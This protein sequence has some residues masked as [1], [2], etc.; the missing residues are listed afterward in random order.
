MAEYLCR[1]KPEPLW[2]TIIDS[3]DK[4]GIELV[5]TDNTSAILSHTS[6]TNLC[7]LNIS[8]NPAKHE[9][10]TILSL[11][12]HAKRFFGWPLRIMQVVGITLPLIGFVLL[13]LADPNNRT[14]AGTLMIGGITLMSLMIWVLM[15]PHKR[16]Y[17]LLTALI[18]DVKANHAVKQRSA[19]S[20]ES[21]NSFDD[22][23]FLISLLLII[24]SFL[25]LFGPLLGTILAVPLAYVF[26]YTLHEK[27]NSCSWRKYYHSLHGAWHVVC[28]V[29]ITILFLQFF[30]G[31]IIHAMATDNNGQGVSYIESALQDS[32]L[33]SM[34]PEQYAYHCLDQAGVRAVLANIFIAGN[35]V[36]L[37]V[38]LI[39]F[40][41]VQ[42]AFTNQKG[43]IELSGSSRSL[44]LFKPIEPYSGKYV[45]IVL[46]TIIS[47]IIIWTYVLLS[48][49]ILAF[50]LT[51]EPVFFNWLD[52]IIALFTQMATRAGIPEL[53]ATIVVYFSY[54]LLIAPAI[55]ALLINF[56]R[57]IKLIVLQYELYSGRYDALPEHYQEWL[58]NTCKKESI[59][60]PQIRIIKS[61]APKIYAEGSIFKGKG[62]IVISDSCFEDFMSDEIKAILAHELAHVKYDTHIL[63]RLKLLSILTLCPFYYI[64]M[65]YDFPGRELKADRFAASVTHNPKALI[66]ALIGLH[67][68]CDLTNR[69]FISKRLRLLV[70]IRRVLPRWLFS[71]GSYYDSSLFSVAYP[72]RVTR[73]K[74]ILIMKLSNGE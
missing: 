51:K 1:T 4:Q 12:S 37:V 52:W 56:C 69:P 16:T 72:S 18:R 33:D 6:W 41:Y 30:T 63:S 67:L 39:L 64:L 57:L 44:H 46:Y 42:Y 28:L 60:F 43:M 73:L 25:L 66:S 14:L 61:S 32:R 3:C 65:M 9:Y 11:S 26:A 10:G 19:F 38:F 50:M 71:V 5:R 40:V 34:Q 45:W 48:V 55:A 36:L 49:D 47:S 74:N 20:I 70:K 31:S 8:T 59:P 22:W 23:Y 2:R 13:L 68:R 7:Q 53:F 29:A 24:I 35:I 17:K 15:I 27:E 54:I 21:D 58:V 62:R